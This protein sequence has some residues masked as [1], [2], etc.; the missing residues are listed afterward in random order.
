MKRYV[1]ILQPKPGW[2]WQTSITSR[3]RLS[4]RRLLRLAR[5]NA[6]AARGPEASCWPLL[7]YFEVERPS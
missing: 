7:D 1:V 6:V 2:G 5:R 3:R 4:R